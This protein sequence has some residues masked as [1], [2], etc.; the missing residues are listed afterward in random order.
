MESVFRRVIYPKIAIII[1]TIHRD[2]L[3]METI[4]S[5]LDNYCD[6]FVILIGDQNKEEDYTDEKRFFYKTACSEFHKG[7]D[8]RI[9][10]LQLPY[11]CGISYSRN[12]L[13]QLAKDM[14]IPYCFISADSIKFTKSMKKINFLLHLMEK[15]DILGVD[16]KNRK[17]GWEAYLNL[18]HGSHFE[19]D[20]IDK[21][22]FKDFT[23][24]IYNCDIVRNFFLAKTDSLLKVKW[25]ENLKAT[26]HEDFFWRAK[27]VGLKVGWSDICYGEYIGEKSKKDNSVYSRLRQKN[28]NES[29]RKLKD[30]YQIKSWVK[31]INLKR[32]KEK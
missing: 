8:E 21:T 32:A 15:Y 1:P 25:D 30:K 2:N 27:H 13:V 17:F 12:R 18:V 20:F 26:E 16:L 23:V 9:K 7:K 4:H 10:V 28:F 11:D 29:M 5:I 14:N 31:Y 3:L 24:G 19:L 22:S 6:N